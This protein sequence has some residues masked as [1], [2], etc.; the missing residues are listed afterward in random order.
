MGVPLGVES[1]ES[2]KDESRPSGK[3]EGA[4]AQIVREAKEAKNSKTAKSSKNGKPI[5]TP[6]KGGA[7]EPEALLQEVSGEA[8]TV[9][10]EGFLR[11]TLSI[12]L[13]CMRHMPQRAHH[14]WHCW[15]A[16]VFSLYQFSQN[17]SEIEKN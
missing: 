9:A 1:S 3:H 12:Q 15:V 16:Q 17:C 10:T 11:V 2:Q 14:A 7:K 13:T 4:V 5:L 6:P 8:W